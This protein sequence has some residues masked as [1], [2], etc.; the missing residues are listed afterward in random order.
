[1]RLLCAHPL[2]CVFSFS[3]RTAPTNAAFESLL[4]TLPEGYI[5]QLLLPENIGD[6]QDILK[7]HV[8]GVIALSSDLVSGDVETLNGDP[9]TVTVNDTGVM[10]NDAS[11]VTADVIASNGVVHVIDKVLLPPQNYTA[12]M[13]TTVAPETISTPEPTDSTELPVG[14][15]SEGGSGVSISSPV[16]LTFT[17]SWS[18]ILT[19]LHLHFYV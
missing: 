18:A 15:E 9:V 16:S 10:V 6:L 4:A 12:D 3:T 1:M 14:S 13:I 17:M 7:Y 19:L 8:L 2:F 5:D 11:V